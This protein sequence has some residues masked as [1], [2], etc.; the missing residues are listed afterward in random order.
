MSEVV[1][2]MNRLKIGFEDPDTRPINSAREDRL[3]I[4][5]SQSGKL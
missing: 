2:T 5:H 3:T 1:E 4:T